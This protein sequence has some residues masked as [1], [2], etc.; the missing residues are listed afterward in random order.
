MELS[1]FFAKVFGIYFL[2]AGLVFL[3]RQKSLMPVV[4]EFDNNKALLLSMA[5]IELIAGIA[6][7]VGHPIFEVSWQ[8]L[9]TFIGAWLIVEALFYLAMPIKQ[10]RKMISFFNK[11]SWYWGGGLLSIVL[12]G[13]L[14]LIGFGYLVV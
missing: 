2:A 6:L 14:A 10:I 1:I 11:K 9:I 8:G 7:V 4:S 12:G 5:A 3:I 13:Y